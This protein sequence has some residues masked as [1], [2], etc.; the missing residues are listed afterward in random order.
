MDITD[1]LELKEGLTVE[2]KAAEHDVPK[3]IYETICSFANTL[4]GDIYL[5]IKEA[6]PKNEIVGIKSFE[7]YKKSIINTIHNREKCSCPVVDNGDFEEISIGGKSV[8]CIHVHEAQNM[9]KPIYL[10]GSIN[11]SFGRDNDGD[12]LL[13]LDQIK[14]LLSDNNTSSHDMLPNALLIDESYI[15]EETLR[16]Y[17]TEM[18][19]AFPNNIF[20]TLDDNAF[21]KKIGAL[22]NDGTGKFVL[23]NAA[24]LM[25]TSYDTIIKI[26]PSYLLDYVSNISNISKWDNRIVVDE[27]TWSGNLFDFY[28]YVVN[29]LFKDLPSSYY[30]EDGKNIGPALMRDAIKEAISNAFSNH[31]FVLNTPL[32]IVRTQTQITF[33]NSGKMLIP[34]AQALEGGLSKPR[35]KG[36]IS[37]FRRI[38]VADRTGSGI[39]QIFDA[40]SKNAFIPP[41]IQEQVIPEDSTTLTIFFIPKT[42]ALPETD[43]LVYNY[44]V[45]R[46]Q[47]GVSIDDIKNAL[48][49]SRTTVSTICNSLITNRYI[50]D[51]GKKT[52]GKLFFPIV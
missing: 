33:R 43:Q 27:P 7:I 5:G 20:S 49:L 23:T 25:F 48:S 1:L 37:Y 35:N 17:R 2:L 22:V 51:N 38:G 29:D 40:I 52:K 18:N 19:A 36:I 32:K 26:Y 4:G 47:T 12:Y 50:K 34:L 21:L 9:L 30:S 15:N 31:A 16:R 44:I 3:S 45:S 14:Y 42:Q 39:P 46:Q 13:S 8:L 24:V 28:W 10:N 6:Q 41:I 11:Q